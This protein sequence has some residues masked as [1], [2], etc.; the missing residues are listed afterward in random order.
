MPMI[1][2]DG[3]GLA[4]SVRGCVFIAGVGEP[5]NNWDAVLDS[6]QILALPVM[7]ITYDRAGVGASDGCPDPDVAKPYS[8]FAEQLHQLL[9]SLD[10]DG[11]LLLV[12]HSFGCLIT[13]VF[14]ARWPNVVSGLVLVEGSVAGM[15][16]FPD[17][18]WDGRD[19]DTPQ[20]T[21]IDAERGAT[22]IVT[23][24][25]SVPAVVITRTPGR[26]N[27]S[28]ATGEIDE[29]W[30]RHHATLA[31]ELGAAHIV[32]VDGGHRLNAEAPRLIATAI[33]EVFRATQSGGPLQ[34]GQAALTDAGGVLASRLSN[35]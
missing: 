25:P 29:L 26:W 17:D 2:V 35:R 3:Y 4:V 6:L 14:A 9:V 21:L 23:L 28:N 8:F 32:A 30:R 31:A 7:A 12:G 5:G 22:E 20:A 27:T 10:I 15:R 11:R 33:A 1:D 24:Q 16:L 34:F 19:G 13:R 18:D